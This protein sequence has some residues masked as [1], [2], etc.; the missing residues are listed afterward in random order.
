MD[1]ITAFATAQAAVAGVK[2][3]VN[4]YK[5]AKA[6]GKDVGSIASEI[7]HGLGKFFE[8]QEW[9]D[10]QLERQR[11]RE[12]KAEEDAQQRRLEAKQRKLRQEFEEKIVMYGVIAGSVLFAVSVV[13][14]MF[15]WIAEQSGR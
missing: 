1:P 15:Y 9:E 3:A 14:Y 2:A 12:K 8:A 5:D 7:T 4:L 11:I 13:S 6:V 10:F